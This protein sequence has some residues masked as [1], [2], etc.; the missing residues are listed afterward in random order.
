[1]NNR[2]SCGGAGHGGSGSLDEVAMRWPVSQSRCSSGDGGDVG[3]GAAGESPRFSAFPN[4][5]G[6]GFLWGALWHGDLWI[7]ALA[8]PLCFMLC[9]ARGGP[10]P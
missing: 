4:R 2:R 8:A 7:S 10:Q 5:M 1:V 6:L 3:D 9:C